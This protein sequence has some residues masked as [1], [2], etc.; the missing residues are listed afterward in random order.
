MT[1]PPATEIV[2]AVKTPRFLRWDEPFFAILLPYA[3][4]ELFLAHLRAIRAERF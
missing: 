4:F 1:K 3:P 2:K